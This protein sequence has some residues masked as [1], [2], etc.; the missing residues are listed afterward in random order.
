MFYKVVNLK[1]KSSNLIH[2]TLLKPSEKTFYGKKYCAIGDSTTAGLNATTD[3]CL[4]VSNKLGMKYVNLAISGTSIATRKNQ[5]NEMCSRVQEIPKDADIITILGGTN[6]AGSKV[7][8]GTMQDRTS[9]SFYGAC[10]LLFGGVKEN[11]SNKK[12]GVITPLPRVTTTEGIM[13]KYCKVIKDVA[14]FY[15]LPVLDLLNFPEIDPN[16]GDNK[17]K[18]MPDGLHPNNDGYEQIAK[19]VEAFIKTL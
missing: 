3:Y 2:S 5:E 4:I 18:F 1:K 13:E 19:K 7:P 11:F 6:D 9:E 17:I 15:S 8:I 12:I 14:T 16:L 10:H